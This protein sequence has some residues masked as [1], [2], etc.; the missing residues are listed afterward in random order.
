MEWLANIVG[1]FGDPGRSNFAQWL[2]SVLALGVAG[3]ALWKTHAADRRLAE[4]AR[5]ARLRGFIEREGRACYLTVTNDGAATARKVSATINGQPLGDFLSKRSREGDLIGPGNQA[6]HLLALTV[7][8][9]LPQR[10][11][12]RLEWSD[13]S[14][15]VGSVET[16]L[17]F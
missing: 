7:D 12:L 9:P 4:E 16:L 3:L 17:T 5:R 11:L 1:W 14:K 10:A 13:D 15:R 2:V 6:R 8:R